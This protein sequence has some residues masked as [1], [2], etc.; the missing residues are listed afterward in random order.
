MKKL[1][2]VPLVVTSSSSDLLNIYPLEKQK[3][4]NETSGPAARLL[5]SSLRLSKWTGSDRNLSSE[6][7]P[8]PRRERKKNPP[9][10][11]HTGRKGLGWSLWEIIYQPFSCAPKKCIITWSTLM[12]LICA[13]DCEKLWKKAKME[14]DLRCDSNVKSTRKWVKMFLLCH[15]TDRS[16]THILQQTKIITWIN[17][18][19]INQCIF[20]LFFHHWGQL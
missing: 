16:H 18:C 20:I 17:V 9:F 1:H 19:S 15:M 13:L 10:I 3:L 12:C 11:T 5:I 6:S 7:C 8:S 4:Q 2:A 14:A